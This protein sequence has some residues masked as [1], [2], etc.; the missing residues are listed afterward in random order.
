M[1]K[2]VDLFA[3]PGGLAEGFASVRDANGSPVFDI[4]LSV[5]K[6]PSAFSTLRMRSFFRQFERAPREYH[7]Y[8]RAEFS[9]ELLV[10]TFPNQW[11]SAC[12]ETDQIA[13]EA[14]DRCILV[15]GPL[16]Q[17]HS[18]VGRA[19]NRGNAGYV[20]SEDNRH[21]LYREYIRILAR[22][23]A[24]AEAMSGR[25]DVLPTSSTESA[26][27]DDKEL[28]DWLIDPELDH[29]PNHD[30]RTHGRRPRTVCLCC[31]VREDVRPLPKGVRVSGRPSASPP[32]LD[33]GQVR[34]SLP[35]TVLGPAFDHRHEPHRQGR[36]YFIHPDPLQCRSLTAREAA[37]LQTC[38]DNY[39]FEGNRTQQFTQVGNSV[40][41]LPSLPDREGGPASAGIMLARRLS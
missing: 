6:E 27:V 10:R 7:E 9:R 41:P 21:F 34:R 29:L 20:A 33:L 36:H 1:F 31:N 12:E 17:A 39:L 18:L 4:A 16:C 40:P 25:N 37:R 5:E 28:A 14:P 35:R 26:I 30:A 22:L 3:G 13:A 15:G 11:R 38:P 24:N 8:I 32:E 23:F 2:V 19:R